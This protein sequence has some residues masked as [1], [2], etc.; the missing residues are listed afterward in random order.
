MKRVFY[1]ICV[2]L[3]AASC[4]GD[5][6][7]TTQNYFLNVDFEYSDSYFLTDS[8]RFDNETG[9]GLGYWDIG[10]YHKLTPDKSAVLGGFVISRLK[11]SGNALGQNDF[12]VNSGKGSSKSATYAVFKY[13]KTAGNMPEHDMAFLNHQ[14]GSCTMQEAYVNNTYA[15]VDYVKNNFVDG[16]RL[17][18]KATG[19]LNGAETGQAEM[20]LADYSEHKDSLVVNWSKFDLQKLGN[21]QFVEFEFS[22]TKEDIPYS[23]C[24][25]DMVARIV[26]QY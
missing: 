24:I 26:L 20:V 22:G 12:R 14:Y 2:A 23:V 21:V 18:L 19:Y 3:M 10:F 9:I 16:D 17:V 4:L 15:V 25:D 11:G 13:D 1:F 8:V 5:G 7:T 6:P